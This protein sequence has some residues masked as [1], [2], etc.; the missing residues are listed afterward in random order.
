MKIG[1]RQLAVSRRVMASVEIHCGANTNQAR[2][3]SAVGSGQALR[4]RSIRLPAL[5]SDTSLRA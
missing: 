2:K 3:A 1:Q 5:S 4:S